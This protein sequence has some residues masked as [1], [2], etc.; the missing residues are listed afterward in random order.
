MT[1]QANG[2]TVTCSILNEN[3]TLFIDQTQPPGTMSV[4]CTYVGVGTCTTHIADIPSLQSVVVYLHVD[5]PAYTIIYFVSTTVLEGREFISFFLLEANPTPTNFTW[6]K[7]GQVISK[8]GRITTS[9]YTITI[10]NTTRS[11]SGVYE[12]VSYNEAG[13]GTGNFT[14]NVQCEPS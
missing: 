11:D 9:V 5:P 10:A 13:R 2:Y 14:L 7:D 1:R 12:V 4:I 6:S 8:G 3:E